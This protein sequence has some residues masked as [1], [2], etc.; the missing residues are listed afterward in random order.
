MWLLL[1]DCRFVSP[2]HGSKRAC[3]TTRKW[4]LSMHP[5]TAAAAIRQ[6]K[7]HFLGGEWVIGAAGIPSTADHTRFGDTGQPARRPAPRPTD[8]SSGRNN[9]K[10]IT[11]TA[12]VGA[13]RPNGAGRDNKEK[14]RAISADYFPTARG[15]QLKRGEWMEGWTFGITT[16]DTGKKPSQILAQR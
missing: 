2:T 3:F 13:V 5:Q 12:G 11:H 4:W 15:L 14:A 8:R 7:G 16:R 1:V 6:S 9:L 10:A